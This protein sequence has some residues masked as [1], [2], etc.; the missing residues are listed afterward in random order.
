[1]VAV[2]S[3]LET[4]FIADVVLCGLLSSVISDG[5]VATWR[6]SSTIFLFLSNFLRSLFVVYIVLLVFVCRF[7]LFLLLHELLKLLQV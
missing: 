2:L 6:R 3:L 1:M 5:P 4:L 7:L